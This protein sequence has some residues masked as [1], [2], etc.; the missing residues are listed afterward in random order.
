MSG[1]NETKQSKRKELVLD[2]RDLK[3]YFPVYGGIFNTK[4]GDIKA[5]DGVSFK[6]YSGETLGLVGESGCGK[7]TTG[8]AIIR[9]YN[10]NSGSIYFHRKNGEC[11]DLAVLNKWQMR[12]IRGEIQ[13]I[14]QDPFSSLNPRMPIGTIIEEPLTVHARELTK[15]D[16]EEKVAWFLNKV[17]LDPIVADRYP[18]EFSGGQRQRVGIARALSTNPRVIIADE[19][20]SALDVSV[21]SQVINL[22]Q[23][24]QEEFGMTFIFIAHDLAVVEHIAD[25]IAV[26]YLGN[27]VE[28]AEGEEL[29]KNPCHPYTRALLSAIPIADPKYKKKQRVVLEGDIPSPANKPSGCGFRTRCPIARPECSKAQPPFDEVRPGH[30]VACPFWEKQ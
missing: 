5:V 22:M 28:L 19:P 16:R 15:R 23:D 10:P 8:R 1:I 7:S 30:F 9:L 27:M 12:P 24:L 25:R 14:F 13:M 20:V 2:V 21:Q 18:H 3:M 26:M 4:I 29:S 11:V 6:V 17:G